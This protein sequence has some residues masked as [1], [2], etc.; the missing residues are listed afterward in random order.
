MS[1]HPLDQAFTV[2]N[3]KPSTVDLPTSSGTVLKGSGSR[4]CWPYLLLPDCK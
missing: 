3:P 1:F 4:L 2:H